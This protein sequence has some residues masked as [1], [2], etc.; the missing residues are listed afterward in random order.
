MCEVKNPSNKSF[1]YKVFAPKYH[2]GHQ[3]LCYQP[4]LKDEHMIACKCHILVSF[5][6]V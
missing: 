1:Y 4:K 6:L 2:I 5:M 3:A